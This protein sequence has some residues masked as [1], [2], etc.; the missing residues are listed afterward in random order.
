MGSNSGQ[1][2]RTVAELK[3]EG[4]EGAG[5]LGCSPKGQHMTDCIAAGQ[6][7][8]GAWQFTQNQNFQ[9]VLTVWRFVLGELLGTIP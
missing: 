6:D 7:A 2:H 5:G 9:I 1:S 3:Q 4:Q 8:A